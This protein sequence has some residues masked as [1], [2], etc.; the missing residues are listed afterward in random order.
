MIRNAFHRIAAVAIASL[1]LAAGA[2]YPQRSV[3]LI[4]PFSAGGPTDT[5]GR[6]LAERM[7]KSLGQTVVVENVAGAGGTIANNR[8]KQ[9]AP[10]GYTL[11][12]GHLGTHVLAPAVQQLEVDYV[13]DFEP[14]GLVATNPQVIVSRNDVPAKDLNGLVAHVKAN[15]GKVSYG[16]GGPG[17]PS[18]VMAVYFG[19]Q[20]GSPLN[21]VHYKGAGPAMQDVIAGHV[22]LSFDQAATAIG[23]VK[24]GRVRGYAVT[25]KARLASAPDIPTVDEAGLPGFYMS[26]WH[27]LW[28]PRGTPRE[29]TAK[30]NEALREAL[31][32]PGVR[33][34]LADMGQEIPTLEQQAP[35]ALRA[36]HRAETEKW[37]PVIKAAGIKAQ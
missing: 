34:R 29:V 10:D 17:T 4:V 22:D 20:V 18:H 5:I 9:A 27:A 33:K 32:D 7:S 14:I 16:T 11:A 23:L 25:A 36:H 37:W 35:E 28:V 21:I 31:A 19:T 1:T 15:P 12:I 6:L 26:I 8:V 3:T 24:A 13:S 30:L 2:Q